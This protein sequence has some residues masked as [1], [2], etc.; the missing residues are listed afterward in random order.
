MERAF[1]KPSAQ[2]PKRIGPRSW[3]GGGWGNGAFGPSPGSASGPSGIDC[4]YGLTE[5]P[6]TLSALSLTDS[7]LDLPVTGQQFP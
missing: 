3:P 4:N 7:V 2:L 1:H 6:R 5:N